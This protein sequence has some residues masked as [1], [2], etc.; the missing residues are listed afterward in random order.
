MNNIVLPMKVHAVKL[1]YRRLQ[2]EKIPHGYFC[3]RRGRDSVAIT[4]DPD[5][6]RC[7]TKHAR[8]FYINTKNGMFYSKAVTNYI[9]LKCEY[10]SLLSS[11]RALYSIQPPQVIFP[12]KQYYDPHLMNNDFYNMQTE[13][14]GAYK[15]D[16]PTVSDHGELKSKNEQ[17]GADLLKQLDIPFKY[18]PVVY[19][20][21]IEQTINPDYIIDFYEID[22]CS[23]VEILGMSDKL[24]YSV[25][26]ATKTLGYSLD[27]YRPGREVIYVH[28]YDKNNFDEDYFVSQILSAFNDMIPDN[29][30]IWEPQAR[31]V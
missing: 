3:Q 19:L 6:E 16:N 7:S 9:R 2:L 4:Y 22:R 20:P 15:P 21:S 10:D 14:C 31:A 28:L 24:D 27:R 17:I 8:V 18:E 1:E 25:R 26:T 13:C 29:T 5:D 11:W 23:Y 30:L 12:I